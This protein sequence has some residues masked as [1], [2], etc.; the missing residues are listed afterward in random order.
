MLL[1][2]ASILHEMLPFWLLARFRFIHRR[3]WLRRVTLVAAQ[4]VAG[5]ES[6]ARRYVCPVGS[7]CQNM[8]SLQRNCTV[9]ARFFV[10]EQVYSPTRKR[11]HN[12]MVTTSAMACSR[13]SYELLSISTI[14][15]NTL[16]KSPIW[17][18]EAGSECGKEWKSLVK[19]MYMSPPP[20][21]LRGPGY[22]ASS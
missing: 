5:D 8:I 7:S 3:G 4:S 11:Q 19:D 12:S 20:A 2:V 9:R 15:R 16:I 18:S 22:P 14:L 1:L 13:G 17:G 6:V 21:G 10:V